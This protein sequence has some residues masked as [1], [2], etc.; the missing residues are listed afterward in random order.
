MCEPRPRR[1]GGQAVAHGDRDV[2]I[3]R[4]PHFHAEKA[5]RRDANYSE[6]QPVQ[7]DVPPHDGSVAVEAALPVA[8][9]DYR[10]ALILRREGAPENRLHTQDGEEIIRDQ[11][12]G[13]GIGNVAG[14]QV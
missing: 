1:A 6:S 11:F 9:A 5:R 4:A 12:P 8:V 2:D 10:G 3:G 13:W 7:C 14:A